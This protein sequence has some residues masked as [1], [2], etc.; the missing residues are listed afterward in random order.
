MDDFVIVRSNKTNTVETGINPVEFILKDLNIKGLSLK[1]LKR[2]S[3]LP[4]RTILWHI[5]NS[6]FIENTDPLI[7]GSRKSKISVYN[8]TPVEMGYFKR[9]KKPVN[10]SVQENNTLF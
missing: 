4:K 3:G 2:V 8:Y 7:H 5:Y 6:K 1:G 10:L 9:K